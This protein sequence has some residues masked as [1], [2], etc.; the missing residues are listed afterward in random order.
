MTRKLFRQIVNGL[1]IVL[2]IFAGFYFIAQP[3]AFQGSLIEPPLPTADFSLAQADGTI[4]RLSEQQ[5]NIVLIYFGYTY[6]PD[7]CPTTLYDLAKVKDRLGEENSPK[8][9]VVMVTVDPERDEPDHLEKYVTTFDPT[10]IGLTGEI[11][12]LESI[13][14][15]FGVYRKKNKNPGATGYLVD[16]ASRV[17]VIVRGGNLRLTFPF[18]MGFEAMGDDLAHLLQSE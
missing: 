2:F 9:Q 17:Y 8:V 16:H 7:V 6:C 4:F 3:Y 14:N 15:D 18:G 5:G 10:F 1:I 11:K 13:W 12:E